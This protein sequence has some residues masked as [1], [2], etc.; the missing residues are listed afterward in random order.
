MTKAD[1]LIKKLDKDDMNDEKL[2]KTGI[3]LIFKQNYCL[4]ELIII[5][6]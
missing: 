3:Y 2:C 5:F 6:F 4:I 1:R